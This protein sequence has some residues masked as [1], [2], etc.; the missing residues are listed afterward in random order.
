MRGKPVEIVLENRI[1]S[2]DGFSQN[3]IGTIAGTEFPDQWVVVSAHYDRWWQSAQD[4]CQ[5]WR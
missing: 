1:D 4:N 3:V 5:S 2:G